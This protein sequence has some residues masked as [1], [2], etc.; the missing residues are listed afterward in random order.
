[1]SGILKSPLLLKLNVTSNNEPGISSLFGL[2]IFTLVNILL[3]S[4]F[5]CLQHRQLFQKNFV[6]NSR[7]FCFT[8]KSFLI[9]VA[10]FSGIFKSTNISELSSNV[11]ITDFSDPSTSLCNTSKPNTPLNGAIISESLFNLTIISP[12]FTNFFNI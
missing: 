3:V 4:A 1:M 10:K 9:N 11:K 12:S 7:K 2:S 5:I 6:F 8:F